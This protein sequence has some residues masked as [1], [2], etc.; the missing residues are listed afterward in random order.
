MAT[1]LTTPP[2]RYMLADV[3]KELGDIPPDRI[4]FHPSPGQATE[5]DILAIHDAE[6]ISCELVDG[7]LVE[8]PMGLRESVL[9][10]AMVHHLRAFVLPR[11]KGLV[12]GESGTM[13]LFPG[14]VRIPDVAF[15]SWEAIPGRRVPTEPIPDMVPTVAVEVLSVSNTV[16]EMVRKRSEYFAAG[17]KL[18]WIVDPR[19]RTVA[20]YTSVDTPPLI[21]KEGDILDGGEVLP[22]FQLALLDLFAELDSLPEE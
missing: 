17:V 13:R 5:Q 22:G 16:T 15:I 9:A 1:V 3:L 6:G 7:V 4:R 14:L 11:K 10:G 8:K 20:V 2:R 12:S 21:L 19:A 18:V